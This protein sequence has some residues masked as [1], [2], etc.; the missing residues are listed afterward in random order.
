MA[1][2][3]MNGAVCAFGAQCPSFK[4][5]RFRTDSILFWESGGNWADGSDYPSQGI[6]A[7]HAN[8]CDVAIIDGHVDRVS[9]AN[10]SG[11]LNQSPG[12]LWCSPATV[13]GH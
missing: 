7:R 6:A 4:T 8:G 11:M 10:F 5:C 3:I 2:Y 12:P 1:S 9:N 13:E